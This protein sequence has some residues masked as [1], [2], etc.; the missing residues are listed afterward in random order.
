MSN[1]PSTKYELKRAW[2]KFIASAKCKSCEAHIEWWNTTNGR[3]MPFNPMPDEDSPAVPHFVTCPN[4]DQHRKPKE[5][6]EP[7]PKELPGKK[8]GYPRRLELLREYSDAQGIFAIWAD[9]TSFATTRAGLDPEEV[10]HDLIALANN[11]RNHLRDKAEEAH[12]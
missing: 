5:T 3:K 12:A 10:R 9:G 8:L 11:T 4:A 1:M 2:Y 6:R 7:K